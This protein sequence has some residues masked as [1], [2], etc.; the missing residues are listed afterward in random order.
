MPASPVLIPQRP[1]EEVPPSQIQVQGP[2]SDE[3]TKPKFV[4]PQV[5]ENGYGGPG[6]AILAFANNFLQ[7]ASQGRLRQFQESEVSKRGH[8][9]NFDSTVQH[10]MDSPNYTADFKEKIY[11]QALATKAS[12]GIAALGKGKGGKNE[13]PLIGL[14]RGVFGSVI[15]PAE[16]K[17]HA[18]IGPEHVSDL[19]SQMHAPENQ[20]RLDEAV[21]Q[22]G[23]KLKALGDTLEAGGGGKAPVYQEDLL[24]HKDFQAA[25]A[26]LVRQ[27]INPAPFIQ[28]FVNRF[29]PKP[30]AASQLKIDTDR[31]QLAAAQAQSEYHKAQ[32]AKLLNTPIPWN[33]T[34]ADGEPKTGSVKLSATGELLDLDNKPIPAGDPRKTTG[35]NAN[36]GQSW[37]QGTYR[38]TDADGNIIEVPYT[39]LRGKGTPPPPTGQ[40][41][42][43]GTPAPP[44][45]SNG[46]IQIPAIAPGQ[47]GIQQLAFKNNNPGNL[48]FR[49]QPGA[50]VGE[51]GRFAKFTTPEAGFHALVANIDAN[52]LS[53]ISLGGYIAKYA[54]PGENDTKAYIANAAQKLGVTPETALAQV[55]T[56][57]LAAFQA[58][59]ESSTVV[60]Q[61]GATIPPPIAGAR[62][63]GKRPTGSNQKSVDAPLRTLT[64]EEEVG[65]RRERLGAPTL[66]LDAW[67]YMLDKRLNVRG[68]GK[69]IQPRV[70]RIKHTADQIMRD[71]D[72]TAAEIQERRAALT[73]NKSALTKLTTQGTLIK[74]FE[75]TLLKNA[76]LA[77]QLSKNYDRYDLPFANKI[78][79]TF[80]TGTGDTE[81]KN[82]AGQ[83]HTMATEWAKV[84]AGSVSASGV[85][86]TSAKQAEDQISDAITK[87]Q[88]DSFV[89]NVI[90]PDA[91]NRTAAFD[92]EQRV[93]LNK[94][95]GVAE[96]P[97]N[98]GVGK[99]TVQ[100]PNGPPI[101][102]P[103]QEQANAFKAA[104]SIR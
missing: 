85:P 99:V 3:L 52:K 9:R 17:D 66:D 29:E 93:L 80:K 33:W 53:P 57:K 36:S 32:T 103:T 5:R 58:G 28:S 31:E 82:L 51:D 102:F 90:K 81:A 50:V 14:A 89:E 79:N 11:Q 18:D 54:P 94:I 72:M 67:D 88:L 46:S 70:D 84:M 47:P 22:A 7:G 20:F 104:H 91:H 98:T 42:A 15:G 26:P 48:E 62:I 49:N 61:P 97:K 78:L 75:D 13:H 34:G 1:G 8:E 92:A 38:T 86:I 24:N 41:Q 64:P 100:V 25:V 55:D 71:W 87:G 21:G 6:H 30:T 77:K 12:A 73:S 68:L 59:Q 4:A 44:I 43:P 23:Q 101:D 19:L 56:N 83:L 2:F 76:D 95:R 63:V 35:I 60:R 69:D 74:T 37:T 65:L 27:G 39:N 10:I 96:A 45:A 16:N 40:P